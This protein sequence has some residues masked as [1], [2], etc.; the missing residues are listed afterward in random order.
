MKLITADNCKQM[1]LLEDFIRM[2]IKV[3]C[4][5]CY[6]RKRSVL[7]SQI[8]VYLALLCVTRSTQFAT[9]KSMIYGSNILNTLLL[10][11]NLLLHKTWRFPIKGD[12]LHTA[13]LSR[14]K[15]DKL[16]TAIMSRIKGDKLHTAILS[17]IKGDKLHTTILSRIKEDKLHTAIQNRINGDKHHTE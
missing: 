8:Y 10:F 14:I 3:L 17:R 2:G 15:G 5:K 7:L 16:H 6:R 11:P 1:L 9:V 12:K 13:I 4:V